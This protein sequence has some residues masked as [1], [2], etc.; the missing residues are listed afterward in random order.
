MQVYDNVNAKRKAEK[1]TE[2]RRK[3]E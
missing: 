3:Q 1:R 2:E